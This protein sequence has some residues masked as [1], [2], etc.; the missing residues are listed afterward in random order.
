MNKK[1]LLRST[2]IGFCLLLLSLLLTGI[3]GISDV[4]NG[5]E[6][7]LNAN[8]ISYGLKASIGHYF[9]LWR[10]ASFP[11]ETAYIGLVLILVAIFTTITLIIFIIILRNIV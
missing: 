4:M 10:P 1:K 8:Y 9:Q 11:H 6:G 7:F 3:F 2:I 5:G